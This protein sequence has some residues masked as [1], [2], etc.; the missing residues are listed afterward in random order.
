MKFGFL[1]RVVACLVVIAIAVALNINAPAGQILFCAV[2]GA[3]GA[4]GFLLVKVEISMTERFRMLSVWELMMPVLVIVYLSAIEP[5]NLE[6]NVVLLVFM[7]I[8]VAGFATAVRLLL[9][10]KNK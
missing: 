10:R 8:F 6:R 5:G 9:L 2:L 4:A 7:S 1:E 3:V